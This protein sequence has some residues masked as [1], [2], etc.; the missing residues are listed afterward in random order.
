MATAQAQLWDVAVDQCGYVTLRDA[1]GLG[2]DDH[3][4]RMLSAR[5][6]LEHVAHGVYRF[7]K[8]PAAEYDPYMLAVLW[9]GTA[10]ACLSHDTALAAY[11]VCDINPDRTHVTV[12]RARRIRRGG[13]ELYVIHHQDLAAEQISWWRQIPTVT[14]PA[15]IAQC[16]ASGVPGYLLRQAL[17]TGRA[18]GGLRPAEADALERDLGARDTPS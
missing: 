11:E 10:A 5:R 4:V 8:F 7:P 16:I 1:A 13:G 14:L 9:T 17:A 12:P 18:R 6:Q 3:T 2:I 15:A